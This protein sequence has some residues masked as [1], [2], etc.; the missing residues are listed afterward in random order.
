MRLC[1]EV[2][3]QVLTNAPTETEILQLRTSRAELAAHIAQALPQDGISHPLEGLHLF[4]HSQPVGPIHNVIEPSLC[5]V[6]QGSKEFLL[7]EN[8]Y[9]YDPAHYLLTTVDLPYVGQ[10]RDASPE[11]PYLGL[12]LALAPDMVSSVLAEMEQ[13]PLQNPKDARAIAVSS[14]DGPLLDAVVRLVRLVANPAEARVLLPLVRRE[15]VYRLLRGEQGA[16]LHHIAMRGGYRPQILHAIE[17]LQ[18]EFDQPLRIEQLA[19]DL[20]MSVSG[21][22]HHFKSVTALSPLQFLK[23]L[24]L[25]AARRL[26]LGEG[27]DAASVAL[28]VGYQDAAH[29]NREYKSFFGA[30]P[31]RDV[32][33]QRNEA[34][35]R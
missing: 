23:R 27:L 29:F 17:R 18:Q 6:A 7:G 11:C 1:D 14:L 32:Q 3:M 25:Q 19:H 28:R 8:R 34:M 16:R 22:H 24:R 21:L 5:V 35:S 9:H 12:R 10:I 20:G 30:P 15:I 4:R 2:A 26:M 33:Q 13:I 31:L